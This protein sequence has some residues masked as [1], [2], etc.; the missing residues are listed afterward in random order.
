MPGA[1]AAWCGTPTG[2]VAAAE[3]ITTL[4]AL[5]Q[6]GAHPGNHISTTMLVPVSPFT[7]MQPLHGWGWQHASRHTEQQR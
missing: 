6:V 5:L 4:S 1:A 3:Y 7:A 2:W